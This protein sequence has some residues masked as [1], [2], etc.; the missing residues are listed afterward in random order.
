MAKRPA[1][2]T[3]Q[4]QANVASR[5]QDAEHRRKQAEQRRKHD[6]KR[7]K[8][9]KSLTDRQAKAFGDLVIATV[10]VRFD[11]DKLAGLLLQAAESADADRQIEEVWR[12]RGRDFFQSP[13]NGDGRPDA[14]MHQSIEDQPAGRQP[15]RDHAPASQRGTGGNGGGN[16]DVPA[17]APAGQPGRDPEPGTPDLLGGL[18]PARPGPHPA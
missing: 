12:Q 8:K 9:T 15:A 18:A 5:R 4:I 16:G 11:V 3:A 17:A 13:A 10:G 6:A 1:D 2:L 7:E 14:A